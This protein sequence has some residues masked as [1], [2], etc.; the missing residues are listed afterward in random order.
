MELSLYREYTSHYEQNAR[1]IKVRKTMP[2]VNRHSA[3]PVNFK[4]TSM[5][6]FDLSFNK[7]GRLISAIHYSTDVLRRVFT[8]NFFAEPALELAYRVNTNELVEVC[9]F[10]YDA[11]QEL[12]TIRKKYLSQN[13]GESY[14]YIAEERYVHTKNQQ[15]IELLNFENEDRIYT[16]INAFDDQKRLTETK[17]YHDRSDYVYGVGIR[18]PVHGKEEFEIDE[19][20]H[21]IGSPFNDSAEERKYNDRG[22]WTFDAMI[23]DRGPVY[24]YER[25]LTYW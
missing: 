9:E 10:E 13:D 23:N 12:Q 15:V 20:G 5:G 18:Y 7:E 2:F 1:T 25:D 19:S 21:Q 14:N 24:Y 4:R 6:N 8:Y 22:H 17:Y 3:I 16:T 11:F